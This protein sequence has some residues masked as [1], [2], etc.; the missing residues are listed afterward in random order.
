MDQSYEPYVHAMLF[1][2]A[3]GIDVTKLDNWDKFYYPEATKNEQKNLEIKF[4]NIYS[5]TNK[6]F[7]I[8]K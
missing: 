5:I 3:T 1:K 4:K 7:E 6:G 2:Q 8:Y